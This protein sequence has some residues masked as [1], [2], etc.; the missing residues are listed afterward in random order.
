[1]ISVL[2][3]DDQPLMR[4]ALRT[5]VDLQADMELVGQAADGRE[6][7]TQSLR[8]RPQVAVLDIRMPRLDGIA[9]TREITRA[10]ATRVLILTTF[11]DEEYVHSA[12]Q[13]GASGFLTKNAPPEDILQAVRVVAA[14]EALLAPSVTTRLIQHV[15]ANAPRIDPDRAATVQRLSPREVEVLREIA[16]GRSNAEIAQNLYIGEGTV[17][18]HVSRLLL[19]IGARDRVQAVIH[20]YESGLIRPGADG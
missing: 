19:K 15:V 12:L 6:A 14:G 13:A 7:V 1:M 20:A 5:V 2:I 9:A 18:T 8:Q 11:D 3:A 16:Q 10:V 4:D 17:K